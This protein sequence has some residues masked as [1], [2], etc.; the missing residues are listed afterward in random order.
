[1]AADHEIVTLDGPAGSGKS[2]VARRLATVLGYR[3]LDTGAMYRAITLACLRRHIALDDACAV[4][5]VAAA[6][7][8]EVTDSG[9]V[10]LDEEDVSE[11]IRSEAVSAA[12]SLVAANPDVRRLIVPLQRDFAR[13]P[14]GVVAEGRDMATVVF[15]SA[16]HQ[17]YL[18]ATLEERARRRYCQLRDGGADRVSLAEVTRALEERDRFDRSRVDSP[19]RRAEGARYLDTTSLTVD[20]VVQTLESWVEEESG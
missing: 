9:G 2:T 12:V 18:D 4:A 6:V 11:A 5:R 17:F 7:R 8:I 1:M 14:G 20:E 15:P 10:R 13:R 3:H 16:R 19:L